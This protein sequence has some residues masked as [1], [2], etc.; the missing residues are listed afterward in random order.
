ML[1]L[2]HYEHFM[3]ASYYQLEASLFEIFSVLSIYFY[4]NACMSNSLSFAFRSNMVSKGFQPL[5][6]LCLE[7]LPLITKVLGKQNL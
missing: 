2:T 5:K 3:D 7:N 1:S 4:D 6:C